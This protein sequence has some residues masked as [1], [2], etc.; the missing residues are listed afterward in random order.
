MLILQVIYI[1][2]I[3]TI[4]LLNFCQKKTLNRTAGAIAPRIPVALYHKRLSGPRH[5]PT[6]LMGCNIKV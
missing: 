6:T 2:T 1:T 3:E 4:K 5:V